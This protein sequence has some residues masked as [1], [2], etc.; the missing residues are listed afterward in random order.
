MDI[1]TAE[2]TLDL[3]NYI[4]NTQYNNF[5]LKYKIS[6]T[7]NEKYKL[8]TTD[9]NDGTLSLGYNKNNIILTFNSIESAELNYIEEVNIKVEIT[10]PYWLGSPNNDNTGLVRVQAAGTFSGGTDNTYG[11]RPVITLNKKIQLDNGK[12]EIVTE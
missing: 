7:N 1:N 11:V 2:T 8:T 5:D 6:L 4:S 9:S 10:A 3:I 12:W